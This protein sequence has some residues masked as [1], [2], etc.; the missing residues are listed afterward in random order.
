VN[1]E[2]QLWHTF[3]LTRFH[4]DISAVVFLM[5]PLAFLD[6]DA[7]KQTPYQDEERKMWQK[8]EVYVFF[9]WKAQGCLLG[10]HLKGS[11][12]CDAGS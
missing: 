12:L 3:L 2:Q 9:C 10:P 1:F 11:I 5:V 7:M 6:E 8:L 4:G